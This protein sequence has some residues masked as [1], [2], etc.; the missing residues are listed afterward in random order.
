VL[1]TLN[2]TY[3]VDGTQP[4]AEVRPANGGTLTGAMPVVLTFNEAMRPVVELGGTL[5]ASSNGGVFT[6]GL[7]AN[8]VLTISPTGLWPEA[9]G[10][11]L[12]VTAYDTV[13]NAN[14]RALTYAVD[15]AAQVQAVA[16]ADGSAIPAV[17]AIA[18]TFTGPVNPATL[19]LTG[20]LT[21]AGQVIADG[22]T[23]DGVTWNLDATVLTLAPTTAWGA[24][25]GNVTLN[26]QD[27]TGRTVAPVTLTYFVGTDVPG[28]PTVL[29]MLTG[30]DV[31]FAGEVFRCCAS[32]APRGGIRFSE[33]M[34]ALQLTL[35]MGDL[36][37]AIDPGLYT[38]RWVSVAGG[39]WN[40]LIII[41]SDTLFSSALNG[42]IGT[43]VVNA[44]A[45]DIAGEATA[46]IVLA[47]PV[48][49]DW[50]GDG[51]P[52]FVDPDD[53]NDGVPDTFFGRK[54]DNCQFHYNP[55]QADLDGNKIG[56]V[57]DLGVVP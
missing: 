54:R 21:G 40:G 16:P 7:F 51:L 3:N 52:D 57:C 12:T 44:V 4:S 30:G 24:G 45:H 22:I 8:S 42:G 28:A 19:V 18:V 15:Y 32:P 34:T 26:L 9:A 23:T 17:R 25:L 37:P 50:D 47:I 5:A 14:S 43:L 56:D 48:T 41:P 31:T 11:T 20:T 2:L 33:T 29:K 55:D 1:A 13:G 6:D 27:A 53:D 36:G 46:P 10:Q 35:T 38:L 39:Q 49:E